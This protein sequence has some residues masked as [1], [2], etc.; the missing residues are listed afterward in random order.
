MHGRSGIKVET[1]RG[2]TRLKGTNQGIYIKM[3]NIKM[4]IRHSS[5][6]VEKAA[7]ERSLELKGRGPTW[8]QYISESAAIEMAFKTTEKMIIWSKEHRTSVLGFS[9]SLPLPSPHP[10]CNPT[11]ASL[12]DLEVVLL[13]TSFKLSLSCL[14]HSHGTDFILLFIGYVLSLF[15]QTLRQEFPLEASGLSIQFA[16]KCYFPSQA[17]LLPQHFIQPILIQWTGPF[18][19]KPSLASQFKWGS[20]KTPHLSSSREGDPD[21]MFVTKKDVLTPIYTWWQ[22]MNYTCLTSKC[23]SV[24][25]PWE[26][27]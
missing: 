23:N 21:Q 8:R 11:L 5:W 17:L 9:Q 4:S 16:W 7:E 22:K 27:L 3:L 25:F 15:Y 10:S 14:I 24:W 20:G 26:T 13:Q 19:P 6:D 2:G 18:L 1:S 12:K